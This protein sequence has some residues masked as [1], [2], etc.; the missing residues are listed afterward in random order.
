MPDINTIVNINVSSPATALQEGDFSTACIFTTETPDDPSFDFYRQYSGTTGASDIAVDF[1]SSS[2]T[3]LAVSQMLSQTNKPSKLYVVKRDTASA[4]T[5]TITFDKDLTANCRI[6]GTINGIAIDEIVFDTDMQ[7][8]MG[9][10]ELALEAVDGVATATLSS[11]PYRVMTVVSEA[12]YK[13][14]MSFTVTGVS[15]PAVATIATTTAGR[16]IDDDILE[17]VD[18]QNGWFVGLTVQ[19]NDGILLLAARTLQTLGKDFV[20]QTSSADVANAVSG[21][22]VKK[23]KAQSNKAFALWHGIDSEYADFAFVGNLYSDAPYVSDAIYKTLIGVTASPKVGTGALTSTQESNLLADNCN[24][25]RQVNTRSVTYFGVRL[26]GS[27]WSEQRDIAYL[28]D[29]VQLNVFDF[30]SGSKKK[31]F[32]DPDLIAIGGIIKNRALDG[33]VDANNIGFIVPNTVIIEIPTRTSFTAIQRA[34]GSATGFNLKF[35]LAKTLKTV[36][37]NFIVTQ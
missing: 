17:M 2:N 24:F 16:A 12:D 22:I 35:T 26:D 33:V 18:N 30:L 5:K 21:N 11:T 3:Y 7:T 34:S 37:I 4:Q 8:T 14:D 28:K 9:L 15:N 10:F 1:G 32:I 13:L 27:N 36:G 23:L 20:F 19:K 25:Y 31:L 29:Q 6:N